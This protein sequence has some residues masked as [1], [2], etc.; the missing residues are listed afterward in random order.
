MKKTILLIGVIL[1]LGGIFSACNYEAIDLT[2]KYNYAYISLPDGQIVAGK[3]ESWRDYEDGE[4]LQV[5][6]DGVTYLTSSYNCTLVYDP[7]L[8]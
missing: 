8:E 3:V 6:I 5:T 7:K 1:L 2:Y 4:Q